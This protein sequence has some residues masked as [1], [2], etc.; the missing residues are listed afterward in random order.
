MA[1]DDIKTVL[2]EAN[3]QAVALMLGTLDD[4]DVTL[5]YEIV[6][7]VGPIADLAVEAMKKRN[8][9]LQRWRSSRIIPKRLAN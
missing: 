8:I 9:A 7:G 2:D 4:D 1:G 5:I 3:T 6:G